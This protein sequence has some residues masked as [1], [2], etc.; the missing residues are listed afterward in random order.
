MIS[1]PSIVLPSFEF[2]ISLFSRP[3]VPLEHLRGFGLSVTLVSYFL[4]F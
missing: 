1:L 2:C 3:T 4:K